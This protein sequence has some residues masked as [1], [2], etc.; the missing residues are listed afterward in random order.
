MA[1]ARRWRPLFGLIQERTLLRCPATRWGLQAS[2][3]AAS[4][5]AAIRRAPYRRLYS[6]K[7]CRT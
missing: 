3:Q 1:K 5:S 4:N 2:S 6:K 7:I